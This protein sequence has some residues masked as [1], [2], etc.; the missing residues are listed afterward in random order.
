MGFPFVSFQN[1]NKPIIHHHHYIKYI[2]NQPSWSHIQI[3]KTI[4]I[5][6]LMAMYIII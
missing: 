1:K 5:W 2:I 4:P 3:Q 6:T